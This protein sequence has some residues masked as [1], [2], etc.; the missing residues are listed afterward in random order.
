[1]FSERTTMKRTLFAISFIFFISQFSFAQ[2]YKWV[3]ENGVTHF[4][5]DTTQVPEKYRSKSER[6]GI[7]EEREEIKAEGEITPKKKEEI[8][9]D[10]MGRGEDYWK[11]QMEQWRT[12]LKDLQD[13]LEVLRTQYNGLT[14][15]FNASKSTAERGN[16]RRE[17]DRVKNEM[18]E[19][20]TQM[21]EARGMLE[22]KIPEE[23]ELYKAKP[24]WVKQ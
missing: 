6:I 10:R 4:T 14:E 2:V 7:S 18:D 12:K 19:C 23:A 13:K 1:M 21:D 16:L 24:D 20:K 9:K 22:K 8:Y 5:D 17:R 15:R 11:G 3:D